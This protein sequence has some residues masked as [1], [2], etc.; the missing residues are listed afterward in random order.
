MIIYREFYAVATQQRLVFEYSDKNCLYVNVRT[1]VLASPLQA[2]KYE[3]NRRYHAYRTSVF[4]V[5]Y[6]EHVIQIQKYMADPSD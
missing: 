6:V 1:N 2:Y 5:I 4:Y 3:N